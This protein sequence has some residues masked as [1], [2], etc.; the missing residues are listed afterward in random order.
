MI[1]SAPVIRVVLIEEQKVIREG[2][3]ILLE[4]NSDIKIVG[5]FS[6]GR[7]AIANIQELKP[8][9]V[10]ISTALSE[11][12]GFDL[13]KQ[14]QKKLDHIKIIVFCNDIDAADFVQYLELGVKGCLLKNVSA[15][16]IREIVR[17]IDKGYTHIEDNIF[18]IVLPHLS[19]AISTL[20]IADAEF[21]DSLKNQNSEIIFSDNF[22]LSN[23]SLDA[24]PTFF[25]ENKIAPPYLPLPDNISTA[26][27]LSVSSSETSP[28][29]NWWQ[30]T[31]SKI[32]LIGLGMAVIAAGL[33]SYRQGTA[34]VIKDAVVNGKMVAI[35][36]PVAGT[37]QEIA[38]LEGMNLAAEQPFASIKSLEDSK[39]SEK[40]SQ[41]EKDII[42]K[43]EQI[44]NAQKFSSFLEKQLEVL[45]QK[46]II[47]LD[48]PQIS[49]NTT[50][51]I[52]NSRE[53]ANVEQQIFNQRSTIDFLGK[54]LANLQDSLKET[55]ANLVDNQIISLK[56]PISGAIYRINHQ[57]GELVSAGQE[58]ATVLDCQQLWVE[59]IVD[60]KTA[61]KINLQNDVSVQL[62][63]RESLIVG[64]VSRI[65]A[66]SQDSPQTTTNPPSVTWT[67]N[68]SVANQIKENSYRLIIN[69]DFATSEL[70]LQDLCH[71]GLTAQISINN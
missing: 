31:V 17:Y 38:Y 13:I 25:T 49:E 51:S 41:L 54:E 7:N 56:A 70:V 63:N 62:E 22:L 58:I 12:N 48:I 64:Q 27:S 20:A 45:P 3:K 46:S 35:E 11:V 30:Q 4:S 67:T 43:Q 10:L 39:V 8:N 52:D 9:I 28:Q 14:I 44:D 40:I 59:A 36:S 26:D 24:T 1:P 57:E 60:E 15:K 34:I 19:D 69:V 61:A 33:I 66:L 42:L 2:L 71:V 47:A 5:S 16:K 21:Q 55:Q 29:K 65:S 6:E 23:S 68:A 37:L 53:I 32:T 50:I 18:K